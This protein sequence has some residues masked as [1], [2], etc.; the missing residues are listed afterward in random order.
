MCLKKNYFFCQLSTKYHYTEKQ[1]KKQA[2]EA[3]SFI[4]FQKIR[5]CSRAYLRAI[6]IV[7]ITLFYYSFFCLL[8][9]FRQIAIYP[10]YI[11]NTEKYE[12]KLFFLVL[13]KTLRDPILYFIYIFILFVD[14][15]FKNQ[16]FI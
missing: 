12:L 11:T 8:L 3:N 13:F 9:V 16:S 14:L 1:A 10:Y 7:V 4:F 6:R 5:Q 2:N 15:L